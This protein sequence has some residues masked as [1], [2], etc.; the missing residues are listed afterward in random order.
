[1]ELEK[2]SVG[3]VLCWNKK[4]NNPFFCPPDHLALNAN[5]YVEILEREIQRQRESGNLNEDASVGVELI[6]FFGLV[7]TFPCSEDK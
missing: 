2:G 3:A 1:M 5:N 6:L 4:V 7:R